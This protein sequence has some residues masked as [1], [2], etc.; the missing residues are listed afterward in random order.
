[1]H[2]LKALSKINELNKQATLILEGKVLGGRR[3]WTDVLKHV[4]CMNK[5]L[6]NNVTLNSFFLPQIH[7]G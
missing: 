5:S 7:I 4:I 3:E 2:T 1:M 6:K